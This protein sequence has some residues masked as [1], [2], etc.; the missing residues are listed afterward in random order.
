MKAYVPS[1]FLFFLCFACS[2]ERSSLT[3]SVRIAESPTSL[4]TEKGESSWVLRDDIDG[5][6][7]VEEF[8]TA[9]NSLPDLMGQKSFTSSDAAK[10]FI[11]TRRETLTKDSH[12]PKVVVAAF[13][14]LSHAASVVSTNAVSTEVPG[15]HLWEVTREWNL[16]WE[17]DFSSWVDNY[18]DRE[19]FQNNGLSTDCADVAYAL[20]WIFARMYGLPAANHLSS[21]GGVIFSQASMRRAWVNLPTAEAWQ[22]DQRFRAALNYLFKMTYTGTLGQDTY[23]IELS[24]T[25]LQPGTIFLHLDGVGHTEIV[26]AVR[27]DHPTPILL[28]SSTVPVE[29]RSLYSRGFWKKDSPL[30]NAGFVKMIWPVYSNGS[31]VLPA[32]N[33]MPFYSREQYG[34]TSD[35]TPYDLGVIEKL[36]PGYRREWRLTGA[37]KDLR[38]GFHNR[39]DVVNDGLIYCQN[40]NCAPDSPAH[41]DW[42]TPSRDRRLAELIGRADEILAMNVDRQEWDQ[43][44]GERMVEIDGEWYSG[45]TIIDI[46]RARN[47][48]SDPRVSAQRRWGVNPSMALAEGEGSAS[49][50]SGSAGSGFRPAPVQ[51]IRPS[52]PITP[53]NPGSVEIISPSPPSDSSHIIRDWR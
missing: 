42:S 2:P 27:P 20:R 28:W 35:G 22:H 23:P 3:E 47:Y 24:R 29:I 5:T 31:W 1:I 9:R 49:P 36:F 48:N 26:V 14:T 16:Q 25:A 41:E 8:F 38:S 13:S 44:L 40:H 21:G 15:V 50:T 19:F 53:S 52:G 17:Q 39:A 4:R 45:K 30:E 51:T 33:T 6:V 34:L 10:T 12:L 46:F 32:K 18:V 11:Q 37:I 43:L 7:H